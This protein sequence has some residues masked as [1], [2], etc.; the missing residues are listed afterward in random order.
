MGQSI[1]DPKLSP[2]HA[3]GGH[4]LSPSAQENAGRLSRRRPKVAQVSLE[5]PFQ[6]LSLGLQD[7]VAAPAAS[8][9]YGLL[10]AAIG[11]FMTFIANISPFYI[12][13]MA[14]GF[15]LVGPFFACAFYDISQRIEKGESAS[16]LHALDHLRF[17]SVSLTL[18]ALILGVMMAGWGAV[19]ILIVGVY[20]GSLIVEEYTWTAM[21]QAL[22]THEHGLAFLATYLLSGLVFAIVAFAISVVSIPMITDRRVDVVTAAL[23][24]LEATRRNPAVMAIWAIT[25]AVLIGLG[26][27][28]LYIGLIVLLP[29]IGH[30][31][32]H[33]YRELVADEGPQKS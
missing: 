24:S 23:T 12:L 16:I 33:A 15:M 27:A 21:L 29:L 1:H 18:F 17:N 22:V 9:S 31:S 10:F 5:R 19:S 7:M 30:A 3:H 8:L 11:A 26:M 25:I 20:F 28:S 13:F 2:S 32:W 4:P 14:A 6:W